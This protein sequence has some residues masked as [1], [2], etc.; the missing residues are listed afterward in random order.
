MA[1]SRG[2]A[3]SSM[4]SRRRWTC[5]SGSSSSA[6]R[7]TR[8]ARS[9]R[10][11]SGRPPRSSVPSSC[12]RRSSCS[13]PGAWPRSATVSAGRRPV[14][15]ERLGTDLARFEGAADDPLRPAAA[16]ASRAMAVGDAAEVWAAQLAPATGLDHIDPGTLLVLDEPGDSPRPP[17]SC[18]ARPTSAAP[19][20]WRPASCP[21]TGPRPISRRATGRA[22]SSASRTLELTWESEPPTGVAMASGAQELGRPVRL[23]GAGPAARPGDPPRGRGQRPGATTASRIV[24]AS[25]QAPRLGGDPR[26]GRSSRR[27]HGAHRRGATA[28]GHRARRPGA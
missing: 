15:A 23:A 12:P 13:R 11:T 7:S 26:G 27:G 19:S 8:C 17:S 5:R 28:R 24:L 16:G 14:S 2:A 1:S 4:C 10:P 25:D 18:G 3:A 21:R 20:S 22:G 6:T 9:T